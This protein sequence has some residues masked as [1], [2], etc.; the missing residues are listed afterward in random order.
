MN[1]VSLELA[2]YFDI[3]ACS[4]NPN[5]PSV[6]AWKSKHAVLRVSCMHGA[7]KASLLIVQQSFLASS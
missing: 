3:S 6:L 1:H 7:L 2:L 5:S 4:Q